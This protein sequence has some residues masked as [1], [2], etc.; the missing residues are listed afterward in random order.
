MTKDLYIEWATEVINRGVDLM[1]IELIGKWEGVRAWL[2]MADQV[3][4]LA[5]QPAVQAEAEGCP[6]CNKPVYL[7]QSYCWKCG[8]KLR[9]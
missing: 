9:R 4:G 1:P 2:E 3:K 5:P 7:E 6:K 8:C